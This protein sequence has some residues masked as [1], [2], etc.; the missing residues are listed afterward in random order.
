M[1]LYGKEPLDV[2]NELLTHVHRKLDDESKDACTGPLNRN[3]IESAISSMPQGKNPG[4][5]G[6]T[7]EFYKTY[8]EQL[9][10]PLCQMANKIWESGNFPNEILEGVLRLCFKKRR[11]KGFKKLV[12]TDK[13]HGNYWICAYIQAIQT[14]PNTQGTAVTIEQ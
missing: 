2:Q 11:S 1:D 7:L 12:C 6:L 14:V 13:L 5:D 10:K 3:E 4:K 8:R 9:T